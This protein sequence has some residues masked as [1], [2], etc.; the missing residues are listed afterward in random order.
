LSGEPLPIPPL[1]S[2]ERKSNYHQQLG[3][4]P[5]NLFCYCSGVLVFQDGRRRRV[6]R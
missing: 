4:N 6:R 1:G 2:R 5:G 3:E